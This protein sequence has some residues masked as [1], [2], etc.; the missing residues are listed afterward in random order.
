M[1]SLL[2]VVAVATALLSSCN[3]DDGA[4]WSPTEDN[5]QTG[6]GGGP[7]VPAGGSFGDAPPEP[8]P[9][10]A[11]PSP[12]GCGSQPQQC[13]SGDNVSKGAYRYCAGTCSE[14]CSKVGAGAF[15]AADFPYKTT[16]PDDGDGTPGGWQEVTATLKFVRWT[17]LLPET[18]E[19]PPY[20]FGMPLR[21]QLAGKISAGTAAMLTAAVATSASGMVMDSNPDLPQGVFC[22]KF[23]AKMAFLFSNPPL[24]IYGARVN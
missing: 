18:W 3:Y 16:I 6:A 20:T 10:G 23:K 12:P 2:W 22:S 11:D 17:G 13:G 21:T 8:T 19:C 15:S 9:Q 1:R 5:G 14:R 7:V 4:C 24:N